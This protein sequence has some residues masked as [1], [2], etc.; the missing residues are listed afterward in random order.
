MPAT[1]ISLLDCG[2]FVLKLHEG[3]PGKDFTDNLVNGDG[4]P[5]K[6]EFGITSIWKIPLSPDNGVPSRYHVSMW[7]D[8]TPLCDIYQTPYVLPGDS[9]HFAG[10]TFTPMNEGL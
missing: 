1:G 9:V 4:M 7:K 3:L 10:V 8:G 2:T 6:W 5:L